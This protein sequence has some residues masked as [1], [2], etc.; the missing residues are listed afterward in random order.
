MLVW[1]HGGDYGVGSGG[2]ALDDGA[3]LAAKHD[4]VVLT[5]QWRTPNE[6]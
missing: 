5:I 4:V 3:N 1:L 2:A 6:C